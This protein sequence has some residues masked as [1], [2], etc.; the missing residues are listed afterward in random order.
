MY[1]K[2]RVSSCLVRGKVYNVSRGVLT[3]RLFE[4][5]DLGF[6]YAT[7][8]VVGVFPAPLHVIR[9]VQITLILANLAGLMS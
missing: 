3:S 2:R 1:W 6:V 5:F 9:S 7:W 8:H 4:S